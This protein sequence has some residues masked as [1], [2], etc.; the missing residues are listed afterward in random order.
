M[1]QLSA[2]VRELTFVPDEPPA[3]EVARRPSAIADL[4]VPQYPCLS[5]HRTP[6]PGCSTDLPIINTEPYQLPFSKLPEME[7]FARCGHCDCWLRWAQACTKQARPFGDPAGPG[8]TLVT[9]P[10]SVAWLDNLYGHLL[11]VIER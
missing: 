7:R 11:G 3:R 5:G 6:C 1:P 9:D 2:P 10:D 8:L 4:R